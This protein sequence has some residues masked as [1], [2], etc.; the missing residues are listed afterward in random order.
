MSIDISR[1]NL[2]YVNVYYNEISEK[3]YTG[4]NVYLLK[5]MALAGRSCTAWF[6]A[7]RRQRDCD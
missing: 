3:I 1:S 5:S 2:I 4:Y 6:E 7:S